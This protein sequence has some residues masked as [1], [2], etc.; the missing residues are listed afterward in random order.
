MPCSLTAKRQKDIAGGQE[1]HLWSVNTGPLSQGRD[2]E[3]TVGRFWASGARA[4]RTPTGAWVLLSITVSVTITR[5]K[6]GIIRISSDLWPEKGRQEVEICLHANPHPALLWSP[7][8][9]GPVGKGCLHSGPGRRDTFPCAQRAGLS[10]LSTVWSGP[11]C[12]WGPI[13]SVGRYWAFRFLFCLFLVQRFLQGPPNLPL[14]CLKHQQSPP[15]KL[16][17]E[18]LPSAL[19]QWEFPLITPESPRRTFTPPSKASW[20]HALSLCKTYFSSQGI[21]RPQ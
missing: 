8:P 16:P 11:E 3:E 7:T 4:C 5:G 2:D 15:G 10:Q 1:E 6:G 12:C 21:A 18:R 13:P 19:L 14:L 17:K 9:W 20:C